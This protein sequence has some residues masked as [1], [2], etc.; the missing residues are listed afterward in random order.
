LKALLTE[1]EYA[2]VKAGEE[3]AKLMRLEAESLAHEL[4]ELKRYERDEAAQEI[5][6]AQRRASGEC[7]VCGIKVHLA[8]RIFRGPRC[9][10]HRL[11]QGFLDSVA[12][13]D[14]LL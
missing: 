4:A 5:V 9:K 14:M 3:R 12:D 8:R 6:R 13:R 2:E 11:S 10:N 1:E 7:E